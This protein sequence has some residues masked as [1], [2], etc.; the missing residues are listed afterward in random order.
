MSIAVAA[1]SRVAVVSDKATN[2]PGIEMPPIGSIAI[3]DTV[4]ISGRRIWRGIRRW[5]R[6]SRWKRG[7]MAATTCTRS[8]VG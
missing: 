1:R 5:Y 2:V 7:P 6:A 8:T 3:P 4:C